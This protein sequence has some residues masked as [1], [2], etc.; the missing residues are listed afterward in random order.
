MSALTALTG[1]HAAQADIAN[2]SN[3]IANVNTVGYHKSRT[4]FADLYS[5]PPFSDPKKQTGLGTRLAHVGKSFNQGSF[6][7]T[8]NTLDLGIQGQG[9]FALRPEKDAGEMTFSRAG[10]FGLNAEGNV[11]NAGGS[12]MLSYPSAEDGTVLSKSIIQPLYVPSFRGDPK[13]TDNA[14]I[15]LAVPTGSNAQGT[16]DAVPATLA[17]DADDN[18]TYA[19]STPFSIYD[20]EGVAQEA[21]L[22]FVMTDIPDA[23]NTVSRYEVHMKLDG[24]PY[25]PSS[26]M[27]LAFDESGLPIEGETPIDFTGD[28]RTINIDFADSTQMTDEFAVVTLDHDGVSPRGLSNLE[29]DGNGIVWANYS[30]TDTIALGQV[31]L[32][33]FT[34]L[35]GLSPVGD[36]SY[37]ATAVSGMPYYGQSGISGFGNIRSGSLEQANVDLTAELVDLIASQRNYQASAKAL[38]TSNSLSQTILQLR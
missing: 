6:E 30:G 8:G 23:T 24:V 10:A 18:T 33:N 36:S 32:A 1:L 13:Q 35:N 29:V 38:E 11:V 21:E 16:Q 2:T 7:Q 4:E 34:N 17:F 37:K 5:T 9:F 20:T 15:T 12:Y 26:T 31:V 27:T 25:T 28:G 3:N 19:F 22:F 14:S